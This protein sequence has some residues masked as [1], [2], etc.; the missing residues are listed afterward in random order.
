MSPESKKLLSQFAAALSNETIYGESDTVSMKRCREYSAKTEVARKALEARIESLEGATQVR[1]APTD[2][3]IIAAL[4]AN[5]ID[6]C[7]SKYGFDA[8]QV[9]ATSVPN[10]RNVLVTLTTS[11][12]DAKDAAPIISSYD[13]EKVKKLKYQFM[14][15]LVHS[16]V[17]YRTCGAI[18]ATLNRIIDDS[19]DAA[20]ADAPSSELATLTDEIDRLERKLKNTPL[21]YS[22]SRFDI[23]MEIDKLKAKRD[24]AA[25]PS[26]EKGGAQ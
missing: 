21:R 2:T 20:M 16:G 4:H 22:S 3:Q 11:A 10:L 14:D 26:S 23:A 24:K 6:T 12:A 1:A 9:S 7:P 25:A 13:I 5:G 17:Q 8:V 15:S 19:E 18:S